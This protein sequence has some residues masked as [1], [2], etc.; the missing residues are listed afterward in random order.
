METPGVAHVSCKA[1]FWNLRFTALSLPP[2]TTFLI[3]VC[4][5][6]DSSHTHASSHTH[7][8]SFHFV[9]IQFSVACFWK[10]EGQSKGFCPCYLYDQ[11]L[12]GTNVLDRDQWGNGTTPGAHCAFFFFL[13]APFDAAVCKG[14]DSVFTHGHVSSCGGLAAET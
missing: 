14:S 9:S 3:Y 2:P 12:W 5:R 7:V 13:T 10:R 8:L 6:C 4:C 1:T 11:S